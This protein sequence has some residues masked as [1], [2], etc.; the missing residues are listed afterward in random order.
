MARTLAAI[1]LEDWPELPLSE[2]ADTLCH[3]AA[4]DPGGREDPSRPCADDQPLVAGAALCDLPRA[5]HLADPL[6][7]ARFQLDFDFI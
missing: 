7:F 6:R 1:G 5:D 3:A 2:W 4:L